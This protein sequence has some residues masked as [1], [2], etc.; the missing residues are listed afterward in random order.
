MTDPVDPVERRN[1]EDERQQLE[2][3]QLDADLDDKQ[4]RL[5]QIAHDDPVGYVWFG[6]RDNWINQRLNDDG[7]RP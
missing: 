2:L 7:T 6:D 1:N 3:A 4:R 5:E